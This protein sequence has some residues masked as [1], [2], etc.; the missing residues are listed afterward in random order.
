MSDHP[1][2]PIDNGTDPHMIQAPAP[3]VTAPFG[4]LVGFHHP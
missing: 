3:V 2:T 4:L 1:I